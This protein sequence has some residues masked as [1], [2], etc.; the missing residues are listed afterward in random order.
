MKCQEFFT[1]L[2]I[3]EIQTV[4]YPENSCAY[5]YE[6]LKYI[7]STEFAVYVFRSVYDIPAKS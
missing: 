3:V 6:I 7:W 2:L 5:A 1:I 4:K